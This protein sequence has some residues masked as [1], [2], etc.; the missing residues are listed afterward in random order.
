[1]SERQHFV[2]KGAHYDLNA[3]AAF[4]ML[5]VYAYDQ[6][7]PAAPRLR[8]HVD[9]ILARATRAG[10][11]QA[12]ILVTMLSKGEQSDRTLQLACEV[13]ADIGGDAAMLAMIRDFNLKGAAK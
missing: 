8:A 10:F 1:M 7:E 4:L 5:A 13:T 12:D 9:A 2:N 6:S 3:A 11:G